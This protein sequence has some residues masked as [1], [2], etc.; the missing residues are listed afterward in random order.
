MKSRE[1][2]IKIL[3]QAK[4]ELKRLYGVKRLGL[5]GSYAR[6]QQQEESDVDIVVEVDPSIGLKFVD[7]AD[8]LESLL[9]VRVEVI[10]RRAIKPRNWE[11]IQEE[12]IDVE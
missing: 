1:E 5:F 9:G 12:L 7:L 11:V 6:G 8:T 2:I 3:Q 10:S 4:P